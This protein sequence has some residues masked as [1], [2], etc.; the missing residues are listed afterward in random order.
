MQK[1]FY[2]F[3]QLTDFADAYYSP[4][5]GYNV[6][7]RMLETSDCRPSPPFQGLISK[8]MYHRYLLQSNCGYQESKYLKNLFTCIYTYIF[9]FDVV[10][11]Q[12]LTVCLLHLFYHLF[13][14]LLQSTGPQCTSHS[15]WFFECACDGVARGHIWTFGIRFK[16]NIDECPTTVIKLPAAADG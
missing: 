15:V 7:S 13:Y 2:F 12:L 10:Y 16:L 4:E 11:R 9:T 6:D 3:L 5:Y 14:R 1:L 8:Y